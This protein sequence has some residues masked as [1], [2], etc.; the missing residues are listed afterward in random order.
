MEINVLGLC[1]HKNKVMKRGIRY[2]CFPPVRK[3][4][5]NRGWERCHGGIHHRP[6]RITDKEQG[7]YPSQQP[8]GVN[9]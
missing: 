3:S 8:G 4:L 7:S 1:I 6:D 2:R 5:K 9:I